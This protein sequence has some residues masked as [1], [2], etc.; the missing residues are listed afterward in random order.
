[1]YHKQILELE[2]R[3]YNRTN[4]TSINRKN[5]IVKTKRNKDIEKNEL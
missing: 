5:E 1:M 2:D 3:L 4:I